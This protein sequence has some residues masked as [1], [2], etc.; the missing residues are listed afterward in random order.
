MATWQDKLSNYAKDRN[1]Y[2]Q[3]RKRVTGLIS[4]GKASDMTAA[5][6]WLSQIDAAAGGK[7][8]NDIVS[9]KYDNYTT[10]TIQKP[11]Q[12]GT[13]KGTAEI[14]PIG[15]YT[16]GGRV[17]LYSGGK[18]KTD[19]YA[20]ST[21]K[22]YVGGGTVT[23]GS[24][25]YRKEDTYS[26]IDPST[27]HWTDRLDYYGKNIDEGKKE[28]ERAKSVYA[29]EKAAGATPERL[30]Q[31][32]R[33]ADQLRNAMGISIDDP[34]YGNNPYT[35]GAPEWLWNDQRNQGAGMFPWDMQMPQFEM[36]QFQMP[37]FAAQARDFISPQ[38]Q[39]RLGGID[40]ALRNLEAQRKQAMDRIQAGVE[41]SRGQLENQYFKKYLSERQNL[42]D[43]GMNAG[44]MTDM[45]TR[46]LLGQQGDMA[47]ILR[48]ALLTQGDLETQFDGQ[49]AQLEQQRAD[50]LASEEALMQQYMSQLEQAYQQ[51]QAQQQQ[52]ALDWYK[53]M[54]P[55]QYVNATDQAKM[56]TDMWKWANPS[57]N[58]QLQT[59]MD[60]Q[61]WNTPSAN[62]IL[63]NQ[64]DMW[65]WQNPS[66]N[67]LLDNQTRIQTT[68]MN[69]AARIQA[70]NI[71]AASRMALAQ[72][73]VPEDMLL[74]DFELQ[75]WLGTITP[76][77]SYDG[78][79]QAIYQGVVGGQITEPAAKQLLDSAK[80]YFGVTDGGNSDPRM[81]TQLPFMMGGT[82]SQPTVTQPNKP[83]P[84]SSTFNDI[85]WQYPDDRLRGYGR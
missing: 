59:A 30:N 49:I 24:G 45:N 28:I 19:P 74:S 69:N 11:T 26:K 80:G 6:R 55:Y 21:N 7:S 31:I 33:Y 9:G 46:L 65:K 17:E 12:L 18:S 77:D 72:Q 85:Y 57:G 40:T 41:G 83:I 73:G 14:K 61:K 67:N 53:A 5:K 70:A 50:V 10:Q 27:L 23:L 52:M 71:G 39:S 15:N 3:E 84:T 22:E 62:N 81:R 38:I 43:R 79:K 32:N 35:Q 25:G 42:A 20:T 16:G 48:E 4:S 68:Q 75:A 63:D 47:N 56:D 54:A 76:E 78:V 66:A 13:Y 2:E 60:W 34:V 36:P 64:T 1:A 29:Q 51:Q 82:L 8:T 44:F 37:D 58:T